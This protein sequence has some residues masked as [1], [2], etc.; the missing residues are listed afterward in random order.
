M[1]PIYWLRWRAR[2]RGDSRRSLFTSTP[3]HAWQPPFGVGP[4]SRRN[5]QMGTSETG[6]FGPPRPPASGQTDTWAGAKK[7]LGETRWGAGVTLRNRRNKLL[8]AADWR[9][10][11]QERR[12]GRR[13]KPR[14]IGRA[15]PR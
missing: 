11:K 7:P 13:P 12:V 9:R 6:G 4:L 15:G 8:R 5:G 14:R 3:F 10:G 1:W 2:P